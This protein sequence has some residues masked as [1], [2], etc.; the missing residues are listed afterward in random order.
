V[1][2]SGVGVKQHL[3]MYLFLK[4]SLFVIAIIIDEKNKYL[5][6]K[7]GIYLFFIKNIFFLNS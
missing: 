3:L 2:G 4:K 6:R 5:E 7:Y 1:W